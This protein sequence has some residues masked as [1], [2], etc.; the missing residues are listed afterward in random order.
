MFDNVQCS[1]SEKCGCPTEFLTCCW[2]LS[3][4][5][6]EGV[7]SSAQL[8]GNHKIHRTPGDLL[9]HLIDDKLGCEHAVTGPLLE[10]LRH[11]VLVERLAAL[12][13]FQ[14]VTELPEHLCGTGMGTETH[15]DLLGLSG[16]EVVEGL[17]VVGSHGLELD[18]QHQTG[19]VLLLGDVVLAEAT[20]RHNADQSLAVVT[21]LCLVVELL[22]LP[23]AAVLVDLLRE[24]HHLGLVGFL[25]QHPAELDGR[26]GSVGDAGDLGH[27]N[28]T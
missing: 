18:V 3:E 4:R 15:E 25:A 27:E 2:F 1:V 16:L 6:F 23:H 26:P 9:G 12:Q 8:V 22:D 14:V 21:G 13:N 10:D 5:Q 7:E 28:V 19:G 11:E 24:V 17:G 20:V